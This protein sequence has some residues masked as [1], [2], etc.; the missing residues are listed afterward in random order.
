VGA[1]RL[2]RGRRDRGGKK[3][4]A[5]FNSMFRFLEVGYSI[6]DTRW[7]DFDGLQGMKEKGKK[8]KKKKKRK[9]KKKP[10]KEKENKK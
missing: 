8:K 9:A 4:G 2:V 5:T 6:L 3:G 1:F 7:K 10:Q